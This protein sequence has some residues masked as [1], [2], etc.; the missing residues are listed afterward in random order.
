MVSGET[1][2]GLV[3]LAGAVPVAFLSVCMVL[4]YSRWNIDV[5]GWLLNR[6]WYG[7]GPGA[8]A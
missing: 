2:L 4:W 5:I 3:L 8:R 1:A 6:Y 7:N